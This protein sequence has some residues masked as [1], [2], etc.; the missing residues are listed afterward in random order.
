[1]LKQKSQTQATRLQA[2]QGGVGARSQQSRAQSHPP[3]FLLPWC[4][5]C[6]RAS[7]SVEPAAQRGRAKKGLFS[8]RRCERVGSSSSYFRQHANHVHLRAA[9]AAECGHTLSRAVLHAPGRSSRCT[10]QCGITATTRDGREASR[11]QRGVLYIVAFPAMT[12]HPPAAVRHPR[13]HLLGVALL[14]TL[15]SHGALRTDGHSSKIHIKKYICNSLTGV[16]LEN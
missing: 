16:I 10:L 7:T 15:P 2:W 11:S 5:R 3:P 9:S 8:S 13:A 4:R 6:R 12:R 1:M 14:C